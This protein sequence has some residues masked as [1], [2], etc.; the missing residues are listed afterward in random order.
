MTG[1]IGAK[2][3]IGIFKLFLV[4]VFW[5]GLVYGA[6]SFRRAPALLPLTALTNF[7]GCVVL[8]TIPW[9]GSRSEWLDF[10]Y[11]HS[12]DVLILA[13]SYF[14]Y[15]QRARQLSAWQQTTQTP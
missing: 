11:G 9:G 7:V 8:K 6:I 12:I 13:S 4:F 14:A 3:L 10:A 1:T 15:Q 5:I 2:D